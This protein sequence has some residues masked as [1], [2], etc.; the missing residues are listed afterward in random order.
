MPLEQPSATRRESEP[1]AAGTAGHA[2]SFAELI[3]ALE[4]FNAL[5][6]SIVEI[7]SRSE[8][9][10]SE[11]RRLLRCETSLEASNA[12]AMQFMR[13][14]FRQVGL[15]VHLVKV[16]PFHYAFEIPD[17][18]YIALARSLDRKPS[19]YLSAEAIAR[20]FSRDLGIGCTTQ[21]VTCLNAGDTVCTF[22]ATLEQGDIRELVLDRT[23]RLFLKSLHA[24]ESVDDARLSLGLSPIE[25]DTRIEILRRFGLV[26]RAGQLTEAGNREARAPLPAE[27]VDVQP[28]WRELEQVSDAVASATSFAEAAREMLQEDSLREPIGEEV[29]REAFVVKSFA[30][31]LGKSGKKYEDEEG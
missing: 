31:L 21:E 13:Q 6:T 10:R 8:V 14:V 30:E 19:C 20:F 22:T 12:P 15:S 18:P 1:Q 25:L 28:P 24:G 9:P 3:S 27:E 23:D 5:E 2:A 17:S 26:S 7:V 4:R 29:R 11:V 16:H